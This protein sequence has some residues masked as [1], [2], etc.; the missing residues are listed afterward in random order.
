MMDAWAAFARSGDPSHPG[1][2]PWPPYA[3]PRRAT[4]ELGAPCRVVDAPGEARRRAFAEGA[5]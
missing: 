5:A 2:P 4:L 3:P 1:I